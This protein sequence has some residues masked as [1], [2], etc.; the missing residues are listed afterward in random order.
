[1]YMAACDWVQGTGGS[2]EE[3]RGAI[4]CP[5]FL[6]QKL[7]MLSSNRLKL[8]WAAHC[9]QPAPSQICGTSDAGAYDDVSLQGKTLETWQVAGTFMVE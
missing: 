9:P 7:M 3:G 2:R 4:S 1:M 5:Q 8:G 6:M